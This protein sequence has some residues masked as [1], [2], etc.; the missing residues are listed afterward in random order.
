MMSFPGRLACLLATMV[1]FSAA[2]AAEV[3][4][5]DFTTAQSVTGV[6]D[7]TGILGGER[8]ASVQGSNLLNISAGSAV[9]SLPLDQAGEFII[10]EWDGNDGSTNVGYGLGEVDITNSASNDRIYLGVA[11][12]SG[13]I[14]VTIRIYETPS[15]LLEVNLLIDETGLIQIPFDD[16]LVSTPAPDLTSI[17][18]IILRAIMNPGESITINKFS[19]GSVLLF[20]DGFESN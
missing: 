5:D 7:G 11:A 9:M 14:D 10:L 17:N 1:G 18:R 2:Q 4:I 6:V 16:F 20:E 3:V 12:V 15:L 8:D 19:A 13:A